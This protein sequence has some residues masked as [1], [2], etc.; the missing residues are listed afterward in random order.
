MPYNPRKAAQTI[1]YFALQDAGTINVLKAIKLVYLADRESLRLRGHPIQDEARSSMPHGP[2]NSVTYDW[3]KGSYRDDGTWSAVLTDREGHNVAV[4]DGDLT[5]DD[6][7]ELSERELA[8]LE[9]IWQQ[10][11]HMDQFALADWTHDP[12]NVPEWEDPNGSS[13]PIRLATM[14][15]AVGLDHPL[16]RARELEGVNSA[17]D[18]LAS[19]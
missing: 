1:A 4:A 6:L 14:M 3:I 10:F 18:I 17:S 7:D 9:N 11:G 8:I 19:L 16:E 2:V 13:K 15:A 5:I 12:G